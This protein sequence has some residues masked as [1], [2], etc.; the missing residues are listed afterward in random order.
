MFPRRVLMLDQRRGVIP[1]RLSGTCPQV[2][3]GI[4]LV[5]GELGTSLWTELRDVL[6]RSTQPLAGVTMSPP[7]AMNG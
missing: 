4:G 1:P 5:I 3:D 7:G 2:S 6:A